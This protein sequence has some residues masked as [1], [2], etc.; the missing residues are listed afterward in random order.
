[1]EKQLKQHS[2]SIDV[3]GVSYEVIVKDPEFKELSFAM[4]KLMSGSGSIDLVGAGRVIFDLCCTSCPNEVKDNARILISFCMRLA[5]DFVTPAD[6]E[7][8]KN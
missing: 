8:K 6:N 2:Y 3:E 7:I 1:M 4:M 5:T